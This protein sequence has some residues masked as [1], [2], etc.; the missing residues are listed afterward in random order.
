[1]TLLLYPE[2]YTIH[3]CYNSGQCRL[4][5]VG[6]KEKSFTTDARQTQVSCVNSCIYTR[7]LATSLKV[8]VV[9]KS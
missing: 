1:M 6:I 7:K 3:T 2:N 8:D 9:L 5:L 4:L